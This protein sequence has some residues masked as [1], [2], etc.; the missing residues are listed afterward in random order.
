LRI[1]SSR[2]LPDNVANIA[3]NKL[4]LTCLD[5]WTQ[6]IDKVS[7]ADIRAAF[8]RKLQAHTM[9]TVV[10]VVREPNPDWVGACAVAPQVRCGA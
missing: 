9:A 4:P 2:K 8:Q 1:D 7:V 3:W 10:L 6:Q 5:R